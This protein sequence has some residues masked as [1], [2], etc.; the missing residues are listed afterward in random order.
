MIDASDGCLIHL[1]IDGP[2]DAPILI[3]SHPLGADLTIWER[4]IEPLSAHFRLLR[5]DSRGHGKSGAPAS[6]T[7]MARLGQDVLDVMDALDIEAADWCGVSLGGMVGQW[8]GANSPDRFRSMIFSNTSCYYPDK[9]SWNDRIKAVTANGTSAVVDSV[10]ARWFTP[11]FVAQEPAAVKALQDILASMSADGYAG[12]CE[13]IKAMDHRD[14]L[15]D[16]TARVL[17]IAGEHDLATPLPHSEYLHDHITR[18]DLVILNAGHISNL[19]RAAE[20]SQ[21]VLEFLHSA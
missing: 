16:I 6:A 21:N 2:Q 5:Y 17:V 8:L 9:S 18:S 15:K 3:L 19:E 13:A 11:A 1:T 10:P 20:F 14:L 12:C 4:Q 7:S